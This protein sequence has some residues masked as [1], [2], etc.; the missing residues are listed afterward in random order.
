MSFLLKDSV[1][2]TTIE[3]IYNDLFSGRGNYYYFVGKILPWDDPL[4]PE[5]PLDTQYYEYE[6]RNEILS[7]K[8]ITAADA[9][10]VIPRINWASGTVYDQFDGNYSPSFPAA[11]GATNLRSAKF[12]VL[13]T[14]F[15]VYKCVFNNN[16]AASTFEPTGTDLA[17]IT[18]ADGYIWKYLYTIPLSSRNKFFSENLMPVQRSVQNPFY[19]NGEI[20]RIIIDSRG[21]GYFGNSEV[22][23]QVNGTFKSNVG[24]VVATLTPVFNVTGSIVDVIIRNAGNNYSSAN[25]SITDNASTGVSFYKNLVSVNITNPGSG[26]DANVIANTIATISTTGTQPTTPANITLLFSSNAVVGT[27]IVNAGNGYTPAIAANT[28]LTISTSGNA[29]PTSNATTSLLFANIARLTPIL[30]NGVVDRVVIN[31]PGTSYRSNIQTTIATTGD[32]SNVSLLPF[33][34]SSGELEDVIIVSRGEGFTFLDIEIIGDGTGANATAQLSSGDLD[35]NQSSVELSAI[36]GAIH[37]MK[38]FNVGSNYTVANVTVIGDGTGFDGTV[39]LSNANTITSITVNNPGVG[40]SFANVIITGNGSNANVSAIISPPGGHGRDAVRELFANTILFFSTINNERIHGV[41]V[42]NDYR[43]FGIIKDIKQFGN[44]RAFANATGT[45]AFLVTLNTLTNALAQP[46]ADDTVLQVQGETFREF[47]VV[48]TVTAN[49]RALLKNV[50]NFNLTASTVLVDPITASTF[51]VV[52]VDRLPT[53]NKF[54][55][56]LFFID[57][58]TKVS[59]SDQQLVTLKTS[60]KL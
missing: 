43:Q 58:R 21:S 42:D 12:Y 35:T 6:T 5:T 17:T 23:L 32:G 2:G 57:N 24:N 45:S 18:L 10:F 31:D 34:N 48:E 60:I 22:T 49:T 25:I 14:A 7:V 13:S 38:V 3:S 41:D 47:Q 16:G 15:N 28:T 46:L 54:S 19:S 51:T 1:R 9:S 36:D 53:I 50:N 59:Y 56:D 29:Q 44:Q 4:N 55:G 27:T 39:V 37:A 33:I 11:S 8:K 20:D 26:Y 40:Y 30:L 52:S